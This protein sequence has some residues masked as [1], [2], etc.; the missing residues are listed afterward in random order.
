M[1]ATFLHIIHGHS[2]DIAVLA[3]ALCAIGS[4]ITVRLFERT[5]VTAGVK[6]AHWIFVAG[7]A[8]GCTIWSTHFLAMV[9]FQPGVSCG[10]QPNLTIASFFTIIFV[11]IVGFLVSAIT[12]SS[13]FIEIGGLIVGGGISLMHY[14]GM[15]A[16]IVAGETHWDSTL[17]IASILL[18]M[19]F[20]AI[21]ANRIAR[22]VTRFCRYGSA[23][24]FFLAILLTHFVG[25]AAF[26][27][28]ADPNVYV[29]PSL[30]P[31]K[32]LVFGT[33]G[34]M[35][36]MVGS[37]FSLNILDNKS[38]IET[39]EHIRHLSQTDPLTGL[40][41]S[42]RALQKMES[43][44]F[45]K[46]NM[47]AKL[48]FAVLELEGLRQIREVH[49][50]HVNDRVICIVAERLLKVCTENEVI[51]RGRGDTLVAI[52]MQ[53]FSN[54]SINSFFQKLELAVEAPIEENGQIFNLHLNAGVSHFPENAEEV[55]LLP[56]QAELALSRAAHNKGSNI[57]MYDRNIDEG[58]RTLSALAMDLR[59][60]IERDELELYYQPQN[61]VMTGNLIGFEVLLRWNHAERGLVSPDNFIPIAEETGLI[62][63][64]GEW[65]LRTACEC[66]SK[67]S[68]PYKIAVNV[69]PAQL[70]SGDL[71]AKVRQILKETGLPH[72]RLELEIT[73]TSIIE[74]HLHTLHVVQELKQIGISLAMDDFGT[75]YSSLS[76]LQ[77]FPFDKIKIDRS[78]ISGVSGNPHSAAIARATIVLAN[79]LQIKSLA[80]GVEDQEDLNFLRE[81]GC[82]EAQGYFF[83][84]PMPFYGI[85]QMVNPEENAATSN[86]RYTLALASNV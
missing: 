78:F 57:V 63:P 72:H 20:G 31:D 42:Q 77:T 28:T 33:I 46:G 74:D 47:T 5:R 45:D 18:G 69:A 50:Q 43:S 59:H 75:G 14:M 86:P 23:L 76:M 25:M 49:G 51:A 3:L 36:L 68:K 15:S 27:I 41:L 53:L 80:E 35:V 30:L 65:V 38:K 32:L 9:S 12:K 17:V 60:A 71:P 61:D 26:S 7:L 54:S 58:T 37:G 83:G 21:T 82:L 24:S 56:G 52:S 81:I 44:Y 40:P 79:G 85:E 29:P 6:K 55:G 66:A 4:V 1:I 39:A 73:E 13:G 8:G 62:V 16:Y 84:K 70:T 19:F 22:P 67:W 2:L 48:A 64:I 34:V 11:C 10:Y